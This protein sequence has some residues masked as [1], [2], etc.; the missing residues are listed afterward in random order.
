MEREEIINALHTQYSEFSNYMLQLSEREYSFSFQGEKWTAGQHNKHLILA[1]RPLCLALLLPFWILTLLFGKAN[2]ASKTY[3]GLKKKYK[4]R[5]KIH[6]SS[7][8]V[9]TPT[10]VS[11]N[12]KEKLSFQLLK[13]VQTIIQRLKK[14]TDDQLEEVII[15]HPLMGKLT[16]KEMMYFTVYHAQHHQEMVKK[17]LKTLELQEVEEG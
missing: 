17:Y 9:F 5:L 11:F 15:P 1:T 4:S 12:Q 8:T 13:N 14:F 3:R 10:P 6:G 2:R 7:P 16:L